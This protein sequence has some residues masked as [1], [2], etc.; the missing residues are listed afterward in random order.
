M[1]K[2]SLRII[3]KIL[4]GVVI[5]IFLLTG[6]KKNSSGSGGKYYIRFD[7][8]GSSIEMDLQ[9]QSSFYDSLAA[10]LNT[11]TM[12][13]FTSDGKQAML[14]FVYN[15]SPVAAGTYTQNFVSAN[16]SI[17]QAQMAYT[18]ETGT[19]YSS[20]S[21]ILNA[22]AAAIITISEL[23]NTYVKGTFSGNLL[24]SDYSG[25][26]YKITNGEFYLQRLQ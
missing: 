11:G 7:R 1:H 5:S 2:E 9:P 17:P 26:Q 21:S 4:L 15:N 19:A 18:D 13:A 3:Y 20:G 25:V 6:C 8:N 23:T 22:S 24:T 12:E 14:L 16:Q 10:G